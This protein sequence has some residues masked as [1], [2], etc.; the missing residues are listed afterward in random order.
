[1]VS[2]PRQQSDYVIDSGDDVETSD[3]EPDLDIDEAVNVATETVVENGQIS[4]GVEKSWEEGL[5]QTHICDLDSHDQTANVEEMQFYKL[6]PPPPEMS[7]FFAINRYRTIANFLQPT[8][9][10]V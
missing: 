5:G 3:E 8:K 1:M 6:P 10:S 7:L 4:P 9:S 2:A